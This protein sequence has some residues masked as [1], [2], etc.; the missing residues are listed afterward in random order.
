M[1]HLNNKILSLK[2]KILFLKALANTIEKWITIFLCHFYTPWFYS[3]KQWNTTAFGES[4]NK[5][6]ES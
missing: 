1:T 4:L 2:K 5:N 3:N 6:K